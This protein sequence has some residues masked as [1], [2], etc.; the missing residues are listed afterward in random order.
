APGGEGFLTTKQYTATAITS[1][2][3]AA[4]PIHSPTPRFLAG[5]AAV[6]GATIVVAGWGGAGVWPN[7]TVASA[8]GAAALP[9][10]DRQPAMLCGRSVARTA[11]PASRPA[12]SPR[13]KSGSS[14]L[15][16][17]S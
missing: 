14:F 3:A 11:S 15:P 2:R 10:I 17:G 13:A 4:A 7:A 5:A 1:R 8:C 16:K 9:R 6:G 12:S